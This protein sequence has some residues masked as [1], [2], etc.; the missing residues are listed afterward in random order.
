MKINF[1]ALLAVLSLMATPSF[2]QKDV[3]IEI[4]NKKIT[5]DEFTRVYNKNNKQLSDDSEVKT[6]AEYLDM[7]VDFKLKVIEAESLGMDTAKSFVNELSGYRRELAQPYLSDVKYS[8]EL[9][10]DTYFRLI[11]EVNASHILINVA[12]DAVPAD[13]AAAYNKIM[14]IRAKYINGEKSFDELA[15]EYSDD[16]SAKSNKGNLGYFKAFNMITPFENA[17]YS[18]KPGEVSLPIRTRFG[19]HIVYTKEIRQ[20]RPDIKV[21]HIMKMF[22][23]SQN[24]SEQE[25]DSLKVKIDSIYN[26]LIEG[27]SFE[28]LAQEFSDDKQTAV[29][30]GEMGWIPSSFNVVDFATAAYSLADSTYSKPTLT[31]FGWHIIKR[32]ETRALPTFEEAREQLETRIKSD[33][34]RSEYSQ[35]RFIE[36]LK[37]EYNYTENSANI[38]KMFEVARTSDSVSVKLFDE[39]ADLEIFSIAGNKH[40]VS[41]YVTFMMGPLPNEG[42]MVN[43]VFCDHLNDF[44]SQIIIRYEDSQ[45]ES[46]YP[47]FGDLMLEYH[48]GILLFAIMEQNIWNKSTSDTVGLEAFYNDNQ[49]KYKFGNHFDGLL[50]ECLDSMSRDTAMLLVSNGIT[51][52]VELEKAVNKENRQVIRATKGRWEKGDNSIIDYLEWNADKPASVNAYLVFATGSMKPDGIKNLDEARG[53]YVSDYQTYLEDKWIDELRKKYEVKINEKLLKKVKSL[54]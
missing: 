14:E 33:P 1:S 28:E 36:R 21:A 23:S 38:N 52:P 9:L 26:L 39:I 51:D 37:N 2:A 22:A 53:L 47:E 25:Q 17:A 18:T 13:T 8:E 4:G 3:L 42:K 20:A 50:V 5:V 6:P 16:P 35:I 29:R 24:V 44:T 11:N 32:L 41:E 27:K 34:Q 40:S 30:G 7:F 19:Y 15:F 49:G 46:K 31:P 48:D 45:L 12:E 43:W 10:H 54:K